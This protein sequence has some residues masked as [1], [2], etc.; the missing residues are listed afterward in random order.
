MTDDK[1]LADEVEALVCESNCAH[2]EARHLYVC[3]DCLGPKIADLARRVREMEHDATR[4]QMWTGGRQ[5][6]E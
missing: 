3:A 5:C 6:L 4:L 1:T 2:S